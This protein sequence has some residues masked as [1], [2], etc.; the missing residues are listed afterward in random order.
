MRGVTP[1]GV[2]WLGQSRAGNGRPTQPGC[3]SGPLKTAGHRQC[4]RRTRL[5]VPYMAGMEAKFGEAEMCLPQ[6][7]YWDSQGEGIVI[8]AREASPHGRW[9]GDNL[10]D[11]RRRLRACA[12]RMAGG[13]GG[14]LGWSRGGNGL[15]RKTAWMV[16]A[17][18]A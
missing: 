7:S 8:E 13:S 10:K 1:I 2:G 3:V 4:R 16:D 17:G 6:P 15:R 14:N 11:A 12:A 18:R 9:G 5:R